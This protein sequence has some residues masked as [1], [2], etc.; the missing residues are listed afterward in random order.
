[1]LESQ[2]D[3]D[4]TFGIRLTPRSADKRDP[5]SEMTARVADAIGRHITAATGLRRQLAVQQI[6]QLLR[7]LPEPL[8]GAVLRSVVRALATDEQAG[9][10]LREVTESLPP[11]DI[12]D[13]LQ[14]VATMS[15]LSTHAVLLLQSLVQ[16]TAPPPEEAVSS[17]AVIAELVQLFGE[18]DIDRFNPPDHR[19]LLTQVSIYIPQLPSPEAG[20]ISK[21]G[22]RVATVADDVV[23]RLLA[24][25]LFDLLT[26]CG[27]EKDPRPLFARLESLFRSYLANGQFA[28]A[29]DLI[30]RCQELALT[31]GNA[32]LRTSA[33]ESLQR[34]ADHET[35]EALVASLLAAL[36]EQ[37]A[38]I[39]RLIQSMGSAATRT[40]LMRL[41][42]EKNRSRR[43]RLFDFVTSLGTQVVPDVRSFLGDSRWYV[44][45]NMILVLRAANDRSSLPDIR[46][47]AQHADL[48]VRLEAI[49]SLLVLDPS[50][51]RTLLEN[52]IND[53]DPKLAETAVALVGNYG[54]REAVDPLLRILDRTDVFGARRPLRIRIF[55]ALGELAEPAALPRLQRFFQDTFLPWPNIQ[56]RRAAYESLAGYP[57][58]ARAR[59]VERGLR[60]RDP[61][62]RAICEKLQAE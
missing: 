25:T 17:P 58:D 34:L 60:S 19:E 37:I 44:V 57:A 4:A 56:E 9:P 48:R 7:S 53:R 1:V 16:V 10:L 35:I 43:R 52:A 6:V 51:P 3:P 46:R 24:R 40:L 39:Q 50:V 31:T 61:E 22:E 2:F 8:R 30:E 13:A 62:I 5:A 18:E 28:E 20:A 41:A 27:A 21:L 11:G 47:L 29:V 32:V 55:K 42:E 54:I 26:G 45:R 36:P 33:E 12:L 38:T 23:N 59:F 49:K 15:K 14:Y